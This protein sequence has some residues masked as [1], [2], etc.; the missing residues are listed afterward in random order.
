MGEH[1][2]RGSKEGMPESTGEEG[3]RRGCRRA[4]GR[5]EQQ[6]RLCI[7]WKLTWLRTSAPR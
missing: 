2:G 3:A 1:W 4:L 7:F 6:Q 5:R